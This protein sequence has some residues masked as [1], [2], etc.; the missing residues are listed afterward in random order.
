MA[1]CKIRQEGEIKYLKIGG[2]LILFAIGLILYPVQTMIFLIMDLIPALSA[3]N[4]SAITSPISVNYH[5]F[6]SHLII[7]ELIGNTAFFVFSICLI[8]FFFQRRKITPKLII[9]FLAGNFIFVGFD[10]LVANFIILRPDSI[11]MGAAINFIR[12]TVAGLVWI[13]YFTFSKRVQRTFVQ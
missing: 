5:P 7:A 13:P 4:W 2:W 1:D 11:N 3:E 8:I 10:Y 12:T 6:L 9:W